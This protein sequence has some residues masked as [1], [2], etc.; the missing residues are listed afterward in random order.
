MKTNKS[1]CKLFILISLFII[2]S[3][4]AIATCYLDK[5]EIGKCSF[6][7][8]Q[9]DALSFDE[10]EKLNEIEDIQAIYNICKNVVLDN[11]I[12][13]SALESIVQEVINSEEFV[14]ADID[15][16]STVFGMMLTYQKSKY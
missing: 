7:E 16:K 14:K 11:V 1:N 2:I 13:N 5:V 3:V 9:I 4:V 12:I 15:I 10:L 8:T 6:T